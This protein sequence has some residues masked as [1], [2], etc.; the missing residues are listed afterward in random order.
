MATASIVGPECGRYLK[1]ASITAQMV[2]ELRAKTDL[3]MMECKQALTE[4][5]GEMEAA[6]EW[7]RK[8]H[9]GK[10]ADRTDRATGEGRIG[11]YIDDAKKVG[12]IIEL[13]CETAPVAHNDLFIELADAFARKVA[14]GTETSPNPEEVRKDPE[15][16]TKF[17]DVFGKLRENMNLTSCRRMQGEY[18]ASYLHHDGKIGVLLALDAEPKS[19]KNVAADLCMHTVFTKPVAVDRA[20]VSAADIEKVRE[21][22]VEMAKAEGKPEQI[23]AKIAEG[24][25][26]AY[27]SERVLMEQLH[28]KTDDYGKAKVGD[29]LKAAGVNAVTDLAVVKVG[30]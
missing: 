18:L 13:Q 8:K 10:L 16:D 24:K 28:V 21:Q 15:L 4:C 22:A 14:A 6:T 27:Y 5:N 19:D 12:A 23:V 9:K 7:L 29:V 30:G 17:T 3:P 26:N 11:I 1:M 20:G 2:K 25:V